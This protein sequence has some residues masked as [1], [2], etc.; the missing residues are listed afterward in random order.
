MTGHQI[1]FAISFMIFGSELER[2]AASYTTTGPVPEM[3]I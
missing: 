3:N 2:N 1:L